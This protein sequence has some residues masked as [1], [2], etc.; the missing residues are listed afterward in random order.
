MYFYWIRCPQ[1]RLEVYVSRN[2][3]KKVVVSRDVVFNEVSLHQIGEAVIRDLADLSPFFFYADE[4]C[5]NNNNASSGEN[6]QQGGITE[7]VVRRSS[8]QRK[9]PNYFFDYDVQLNL[10][11]VVS[12]FLLGDSSEEEPKAYIEAQGMLAKIGNYGS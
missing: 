6:I 11:T 7:G 4:S 5:R 10:F 8:R 1:K 9:Q 2:K 3:L 12:S